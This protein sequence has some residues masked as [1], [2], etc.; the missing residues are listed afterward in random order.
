MTQ[1]PQTVDQVTGVMMGSTRDILTNA[2]KAEIITDDDMNVAVDILATIKEKRKA[3]EKQRIE[4]TGPINKS[5]KVIN[6]KFKEVTDPLDKAEAALKPK[7]LAHQEIAEQKKREEALIERAKVQKE[8]RDKAAEAQEMGD[9]DTAS[10]LMTQASSVYVKPQEAARG[11]FTGAKTVIN[12]R[13]KYEVTD[14]N[15]LCKAGYVL[16]DTVAINKQIK[17]GERKIPGLR[18]YQE[19]SLSCRA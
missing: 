4:M 13:W 5:L 14:I 12:K 1:L 2:F 9:E 3:I 15:A 19:S 16:E 17:S 6:G 8:I 10:E 18:I 7:I 11:G